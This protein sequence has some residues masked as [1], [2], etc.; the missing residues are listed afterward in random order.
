[1]DAGLRP[2]VKE[3]ENESP[4]FANDSFIKCRWSGLF[5]GDR[6]L[7]R[8][9]CNVVAPIQLF[10]YLTTSAMVK[11]PDLSREGKMGALPPE[12]ILA[13]SPSKQKMYCYPSPHLN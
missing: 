5:I 8:R 10:G 7:T 4:R 12:N 6:I 2:N 1:M 3:T 11:A 13:H 9:D